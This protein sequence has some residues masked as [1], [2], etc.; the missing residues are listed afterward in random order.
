LVDG[1]VNFTEGKGG[2]KF[3]NV[4]PLDAGNN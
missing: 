2:R 4:Q 3:I 1:T